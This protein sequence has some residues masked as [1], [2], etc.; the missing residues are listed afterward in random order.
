MESTML[1][2][3]DRMIE[4]GREEGREAG[5]L[6]AERDLLLRQI[7]VR[8]QNVPDALAQHIAQA[9]RETLDRLGERVVLATTLDELVAG[10]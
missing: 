10:L 3:A 1:T 4:R 9:D 6:A 7:R 5:A 8:F 2:W